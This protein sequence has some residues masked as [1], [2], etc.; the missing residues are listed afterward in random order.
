MIEI[1][2]FCDTIQYHE[3]GLRWKLQS[4]RTLPT[5]LLKHY[6]PVEETRISAFKSK[7]EVQQMGQLNKINRI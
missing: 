4:E 6:T 2:I 1:A 3:P 5:F 7:K